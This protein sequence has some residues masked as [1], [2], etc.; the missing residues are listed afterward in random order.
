MLLLPDQ[1]YEES[2]DQKSSVPIKALKNLLSNTKLE[3]HITKIDSDEKISFDNSKAKSIKN[4]SNTT[5]DVHSTEAPKVHTS[6]TEDFEKV[7]EFFNN[8]PEFIGEPLGPFSIE[9]AKD[10]TKTDADL[11][12]ECE[13]FLNK[14]RIKPE[15]FC[16]YRKKLE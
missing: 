15:F 2:K 12:K 3:P 14:Y 10:G 8:I 4:V 5:N 7:S 16:R 6:K 11:L 9:D 13:R 1:T